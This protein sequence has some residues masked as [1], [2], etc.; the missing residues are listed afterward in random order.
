[1]KNKKI[2]I[3]CIGC[4]TIGAGWVARLIQNGISVKIYDP[5]PLSKSRLYSMLENSKRAYKK[6]FPNKRV[7]F[8][9]FEYYTDISK[10]LENI[11][12]IIESVPE[13]IDIKQQ[14]YEKIDEIHRINLIKELI[15]D[16]INGA[17][18]RCIGF[19]NRSNEIRNNTG[20]KKTIRKI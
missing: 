14:I 7:T 11:D 1:M 18:D 19:N 15:E 10:A 12:F 2:N 4:G 9:T 5:T 6:L 16:S 20:I 17:I 13:R 3:S 8:G